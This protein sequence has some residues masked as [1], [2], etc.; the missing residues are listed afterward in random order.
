MTFQ[1]GVRPADLLHEREGISGKQTNMVGV[2]WGYELPL[3]SALPAFKNS[4]F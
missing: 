1:G 4:P 3:I 2:V